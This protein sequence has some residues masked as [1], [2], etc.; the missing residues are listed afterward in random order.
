V[1]AFADGG[2]ITDQVWA[3]AFDLT[4]GNKPIKVL[5]AILEAALDGDASAIAELC[6][7]GGS[8]AMLDG[9]ITRDRGSKLN[10][11][12]A[13]AVRTV[14]L[15]LRAYRVVEELA[16]SKGGL[17]TLHSLAVAHIDEGNAKQFR[18]YDDPDGGFVDGD[19]ILEP[20]SAQTEIYSEW[21]I[22]YTAEPRRSQEAID[23][24][25]ATVPGVGGGGK[26][27][28]PEAVK[29][30]RLLLAGAETV[31]DAAN[32]LAVLSEQ[33]GKVVFGGYEAVETV[34]D[35]LQKTRDVLAHYG[36]VKRVIIVD[37][38]DEGDDGSLFGDGGASLARS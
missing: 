23:T 12:S 18:S 10:A 27:A 9:L 17:K 6:V 4:Q 30:R 3:V 38:D 29:L 25:T 22:V 7:L 32:G 34:K 1:N 13:G 2:P 21:H 33:Q 28:E 31:R 37:D 36:P 5:D 14:P 19:P 11:S 20:N 8:A 15:R 26:P 16:K 35:V 24:A